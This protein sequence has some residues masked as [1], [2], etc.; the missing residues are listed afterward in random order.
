MII[1]VCQKYDAKATK[2]LDWY[3]REQTGN[4]HKQG[5]FSLRR[6]AQTVDDMMKEHFDNVDTL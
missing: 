5:R 2:V 3:W 6:N 1:H 4:P